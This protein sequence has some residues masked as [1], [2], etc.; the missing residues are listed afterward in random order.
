MRIGFDTRCFEEEKISGVGEYTLELLKHLLEK[1]CESQYVIFS[2]SF[3]QGDNRYF[4]WLEKYPNAELKRFSFPNKILNFCFWYLNWP[5]IDKMIGGADFFFAPNINFLSVSNKCPLI[6]TFHDLSFER[7]PH[8]FSPKTRLWHK[9][10]VNPRHIARTAQRIIAVSDS[11][12]EDLKEIY[13][14]NSENIEVI[15]HGVSHDFRVIDKNDHQLLQI[16]K[17]YSLPNKFVLY[18][19]NIE[20]RKNIISIVSAHK[21]LASKNPKLAEYELVLAGNVSPLCRDLIEKNH[22]KTC[23]YIARE[24]RPYVYN[25]A[26]LFV[27]PSFFEG[28][29]LPVLEAMACGAPVI[30]SNN[31]S[32]PEVA[33]DAAILIDPNRPSELADAMEAVLADE[34]LYSKL[35]ERGPIQA[36][37]FN[38]RKCANKTL[39]I[40]IQT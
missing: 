17:K 1:D 21:K 22:I 37:K 30:T 39:E 6:T 25:L 13:S 32:I 4:K 31:S 16:Q 29:G 24:D 34:K 40:M 2:N 18:L 28:F 10:F 9:Y 12:K 3:Q 27:Y 20:P 35:T 5:K 11:T 38:W 36:Q 23:G 15:P 14:T 26:Y 33:E 8:F 7:F 19:G